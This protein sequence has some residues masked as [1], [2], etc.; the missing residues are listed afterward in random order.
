MVDASNAGSPVQFVAGIAAA[1]QKDFAKAEQLAASLKKSREQNE[2][3]GRSYEAKPIAIMEK[4]VMAVIAI[5][6][7]RMDD[8][9]RLARE[10]TEVELTLDPPSGPPEPMKPSFELYGELL[11]QANRAKDA[12][13]QFAESLLRMPN[14]VNSLMGSAKSYSA[15]GDTT[16]AEKLQSEIRK[17]Q[18]RN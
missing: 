12:T 13:A 15:Q 9:L 7:G 16:K 14:R 6:Q 3:S 10:A 1:K 2:A 18:G 11:L 5:E 4:E 17:I 8:A